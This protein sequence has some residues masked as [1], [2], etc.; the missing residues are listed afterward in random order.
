M[1]KKRCQVSERL[2]PAEPSPAGLS[3]AGR[4]SGIQM[5]TDLCTYCPQLDCFPGCKLRSR[6]WEF[7]WP[8][9]PVPLPSRTSAAWLCIHK[10][11]AKLHPPQHRIPTKP[12]TKRKPV[13]MWRIS[14]LPLFLI[15]HSRIN[16]RDEPPEMEK[17]QH[18]QLATG[19][20]PEDIPCICF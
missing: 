5:K 6:G 14:S 20:F 7:L 13:T 1:G 17:T 12:E 19:G 16:P 10:L 18:W 11:K 8:L 2:L 4:A 3:L 9:E 15:L